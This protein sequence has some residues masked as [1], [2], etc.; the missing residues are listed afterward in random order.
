VR[1]LIVL[2]LFIASCA[3]QPIIRKTPYAVEKPFDLIDSVVYSKPLLSFCA[4]EKNEMFVLDGS[5]E[6]IYR[7][8]NNLLVADTIALPQK[9]NFLKGIATDNLFIY[10][11]SDNS[12][13]QFDP[14]SQKLATVINWQDRI[15]ISGIAV[16]SQGEIFISDRLN[17][18]IVFVNSLGKINK[19]NT[20][21]KDLFVP[22]GLIYDNE[23]TQLLVINKAQNRIEIFSRIGSILSVINLPDLACS[24]I[25]VNKD[26]IFV[27]AKNKKNL[28]YRIKSKADWQKIS[29]NQSIINIAFYNNLLLLLDNSKGIFVYQID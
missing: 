4:N 25:A 5:G 2:I 14:T 7:F 29:V 22:A 8:S 6:K 17:N 20:T 3:T 23:N 26:K 27:W 13:Y 19:F 16:T 24:N 21:G 10:L 9:I 28:Y 11:Y 12:L 15:N 1:Y 18:Q